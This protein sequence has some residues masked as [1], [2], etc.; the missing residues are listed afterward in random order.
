M[1]L[2]K[3]EFIELGVESSDTLHAVQTWRCHFN[4]IILKPLVPESLYNGGNLHRL[5]RRCVPATPP[6]SLYF[7]SWRAPHLLGT[8]SLRSS[9]TPFDGGGCSVEFL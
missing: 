2:G 8:P 4:H 5:A 9:E 7:Y 3:I 6:I 1:G